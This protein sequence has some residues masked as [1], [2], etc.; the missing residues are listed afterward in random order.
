LDRF[1]YVTVVEH[2]EGIHGD[3]ITPSNLFLIDAD[4]TGHIP[5]PMILKELEPKKVLEQKYI[6]SFLG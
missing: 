4:G 2:E 3:F 6:D 5:F 1:L